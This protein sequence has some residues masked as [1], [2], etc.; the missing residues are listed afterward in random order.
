[1]G[2]V[3]ANE[4][5]IIG[6]HGMQAHQFPGMLDMIVSGKI[7][8]QRMLGKVVTLEQGIQELMDLNSFKGTGVTVIGF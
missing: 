1:M 8:P 3:I 6:S 7:Q 2:A 5:E 4:L